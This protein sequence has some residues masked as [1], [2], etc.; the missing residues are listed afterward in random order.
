[1][2]NAGQLKQS[3][4]KIYNAI[5]MQMFHIGVQRQSVDFIGNKIVIVSINS[6][7]PALKVLESEYPETVQQVD[8]LLSAQF[9]KRIWA[10]LETQLGFHIVTVF[11]DYDAET[12]FS[13]TT[14]LLDCDITYYLD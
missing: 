7:V 5:N 4:L 13:G 8:Y 14:I 6:R 1:M 12:E 3:I 9:K 2:P 11:K 10:E